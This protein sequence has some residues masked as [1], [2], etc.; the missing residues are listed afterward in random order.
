MSNGAIRLTSSILFPE[1]TSEDT[2]GPIKCG[3]ELMPDTEAEKMDG[4]DD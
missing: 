3:K 1:S 4:S 2:I